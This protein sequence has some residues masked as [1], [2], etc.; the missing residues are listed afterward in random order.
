M[1]VLVGVPRRGRL[2][3]VGGESGA[4]G[5]AP[6][7]RMSTGARRRALPLEY[8]DEKE[9]VRQ[10]EAVLELIHNPPES[11]PGLVENFVGRL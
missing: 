3:P 2:P 9:L 1:T 7:F 4:T 8:L 11:V 6:H 5:G 10:R